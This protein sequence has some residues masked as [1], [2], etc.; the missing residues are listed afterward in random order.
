MGN[1]GAY[2]TMTT[3]AKECKS[4]GGVGGVVAVSGYLV[5]RTGEAGIKKG[6]KVIKKLSSKNKAVISEYSIKKNGVS[7]EGLELKKGDLIRVLEKAEDAVLIEL[8]GDEDSPY[9]VDAK[10]LKEISDYEEV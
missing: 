6:V 8:V 10:Y 3:L 2:Q 5:L 4:P 9:F 1:L 7:N